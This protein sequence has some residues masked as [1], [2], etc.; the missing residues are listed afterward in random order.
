MK[1]EISGQIV[2][3]YSYIRFHKNPS[4]GSHVVTFG[5]TN[6]QTD[7][8]KLRVTCR[9]FAKAPKHVNIGVYL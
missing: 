7:T 6:G 3:K 2:E 9:N 5:Q 1:L 4:G 8:T